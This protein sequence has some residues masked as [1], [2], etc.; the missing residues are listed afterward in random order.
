MARTRTDAAERAKQ[1]RDV[2]EQVSAELGEKVGVDKARDYRRAQ[3]ATPI[4]EGYV[5]RDREVEF[6]PA[7]CTRVGQVLGRVIDYKI[8]RGGFVQLAIQTSNEFVH[9]LADASLVSQGHLLLI[10]LDELFVPDDAA[11]S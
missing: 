6:D 9:T 3:K 4:G 10:T 1:R 8:I 2:A 7:D 11:A 5:I